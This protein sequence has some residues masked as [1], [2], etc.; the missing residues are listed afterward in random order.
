VYSASYVLSARLNHSLQCTELT[1][2]IDLQL[3][4]IEEVLLIGFYEEA[5]VNPFLAQMQDEVRFRLRYNLC[6]F[7]GCSGARSHKPIT[8]R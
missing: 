8:R 3:P 2:F 7:V 1:Y 5:E 4:E 6:G